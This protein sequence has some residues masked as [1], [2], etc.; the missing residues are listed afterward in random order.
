[1]I[2]RT[3]IIRTIIRNNFNY[4]NLFFDI[5]VGIFDFCS[6]GRI[7]KDLLFLMEKLLRIGRRTK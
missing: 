5:F 7:W 1:M 3:L 6:I 2:E 4:Y